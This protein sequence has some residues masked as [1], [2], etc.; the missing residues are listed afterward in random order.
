[1]TSVGHSQTPAACRQS[2]RISRASRVGSG[3]PTAAAS[4]LQ[5]FI[6]AEACLTSAFFWLGKAGGLELLAN[7][8]TTSLAWGAGSQNPYCLQALNVEF[9]L[10]RKFYQRQQALQNIKGFVGARREENRYPR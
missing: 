3:S 4:T 10:L 7:S 1:L 5:H 8:Y 6:G 2:R 9:D